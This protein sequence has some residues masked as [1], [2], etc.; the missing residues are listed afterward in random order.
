[1]CKIPY[2]M[3]QYLDQQ[4]KRHHR[5][6]RAKKTQRF[7]HRQ[8]DHVPHRQDTA[9]HGRSARCNTPSSASGTLSVGCTCTTKCNYS[10]WNAYNGQHN[11]HHGSGQSAHSATRTWGNSE[12]QGIW[13]NTET[14]AWRHPDTCAWGESGAPHTHVALLGTGMGTAHQKEPQCPHTK[15]SGLTMLH[16]LSQWPLHLPMHKDTTRPCDYV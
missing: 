8:T 4:G 5:P 1:M 11:L 15:R 13:H 14:C 7:R 9:S 2:P 10:A 3:A 6:V 16:T 12:S